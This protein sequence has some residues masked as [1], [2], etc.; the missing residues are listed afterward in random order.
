MALVEKRLVS[1]AVDVYVA[2]VVRSAVAAAVVVAAVV[3]GN[4]TVRTESRISV[5]NKAVLNESSTIASCMEKC[6]SG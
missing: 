6:L 5:T 2:V 1:K 4:S 3:D